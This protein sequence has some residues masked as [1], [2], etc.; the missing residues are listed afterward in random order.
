MLPW[1]HWTPR[2]PPRATVEQ[3]LVQ[4]R[5]AR[6]VDVSVRRLWRRM[7]GRNWERTWRDDIGPQIS[8]LVTSGQTAAANASSNYIADVLEEFGMPVDVPTVFQPGG[9]AGVTGGGV[10]VEDAAYQAVVE[11]AQAQYRT[12]VESGDLLTTE[13]ALQAG[14]SFLAELTASMMADAMR[15]AEEVAMAQR[16][17]VDGY[18]RIVEPGACSR[19]IILAGKFF[20]FN[21]GF[22][23]HPRCRC[24]HAPAPSDPDR[25]RDLIAA[26]S[27]ERLFESL[28]EAE[29][30]RIFT[31]AGAEAIR[32]G[33]DM[34][35]VVNARSGMST[36]QRMSKNEAY[37]EELARALAEGVNKTEARRRAQ[38]AFAAATGAGRLIRNGDGLYV[39]DAG[40]SMRG[41]F[42]K[43][44][45][46]RLAKG[47]PVTYVRLM[48][49][50]I[51]EIAGDDR[52]EALR[53]LRVHGYIT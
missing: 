39:T 29:Q 28:T 43:L 8:G 47:L 17:W 10:A 35:Q 2:V 9:F 27:P 37:A 11:A 36:A 42:S 40:T 15:A 18:V 16:P 5:L 52:D 6:V 12:D 25:L 19:C 30:D 41:R 21:E 51:F 53:L 49:E 33:A 50:S 20:L 46:A 24:N 32:K 31:R 22:L 14:E 3:E 23:R 34:G 1:L 7:R 26:E 44:Q 13:R 38:A 4:R 48:P 45:E